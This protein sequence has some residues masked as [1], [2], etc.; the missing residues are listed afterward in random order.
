[1]TDT[2]ADASPAATLQVIG[3]GKMGLA[4]VGG[5]LASGWA[6]ES[7]IVVVEALESQRAA[8]AEQFP[9]AVVREQPVAG[10]DTLLALKPWL[11]V[12]VAATLEAPG[13]VMS[14]AAG[15]TIA[16]L[17]AVLPAGTPVIRVMPNTPALVGAGASAIAGG[18][19][20]SSADIEWATGLLSSVGVVEVVSEKQLDAVTGLSGSGPAYVFLV[21]EALTDAGVRVGLTR[22]TAERLANQT[23]LGAGAMLAAGDESAAELRAGVTTPGGTTAAGLGELERHALRAAFQDAVIAATTRSEELGRS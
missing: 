10:V 1:M 23:I 18:H 5:L 12:E 6:E 21:A 4:L 11:T 2:A 3:G 20:A 17:E 8:I 16:A 14:V 7:A 22:A 19:S 9:A 15:V 13:R